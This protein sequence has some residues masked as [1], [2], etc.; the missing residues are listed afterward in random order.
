M[1]DFQSHLL[2]HL[3]FDFATQDA[4]FIDEPGGGHVLEAKD[5]VDSGVIGDDNGKGDAL[6]FGK[7]FDFFRL[8]LGIQ[9]D[10]DE[11]VVFQLVINFLQFGQFGYAGRAVSS[12]EVD[13]DHLARIAVE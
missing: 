13:E 10:D 6:F 1:C 5:G 11:A 7:G 12:P 3:T 8:F 2:A 4:V 9:A